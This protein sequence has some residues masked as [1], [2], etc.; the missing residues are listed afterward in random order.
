MKTLAKFYRLKDNSVAKPSVY[1]GTQ[2]REHRLPDNPNKTMW[3]MSAEKYLK[4]ALRNLDTILLK[5]NKRLPT[6]VV[7]PLSNNYRPELDVSPLLDSPQHTLYMQ[8]MGILRWAVELGRIDIHLSV[9]LLAQCDE[10]CDPLLDQGLVEVSGSF[11][12]L[13]FASER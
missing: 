4:E 9:A 11:V 2:I 1:L 8:L 13:T 10:T 12:L 3:S 7:T 5:E 6:K